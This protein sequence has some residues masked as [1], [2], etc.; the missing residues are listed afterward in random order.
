ML[1]EEELD[2][3]YNSITED[4][5]DDR[6]LAQY[7][8][9]VL[10]QNCGTQTEV[11]GW[12]IEEKVKRKNFDRVKYS[13]ESRKRWMGP[14]GMGAVIIPNKNHGATVKLVFKT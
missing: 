6:G 8:Q 12:E 14:A 2:S 13:A 4:L 7:V 1:A 9:D 10:T 3:I 11:N 5:P